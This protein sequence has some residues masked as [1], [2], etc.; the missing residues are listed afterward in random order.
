MHDYTFQHLTSKWTYERLFY[1]VS[2]WCFFEFLP[3][4]K[5]KKD[6]VLFSFST[7]LDRKPKQKH[8]MCRR[9]QRVST[10]VKLTPLALLE[11]SLT[12]GLGP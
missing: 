3:S 9:N 11:E 7:S 4:L 12:Y 10:L 1:C 6:I 5:K 8:Y 2:F